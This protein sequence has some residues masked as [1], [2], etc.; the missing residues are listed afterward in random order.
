[1]NIMMYVMSSEYKNM[2]IYM[3]MNLSC[4]IMCQMFCDRMKT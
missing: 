1:M 2:K 3:P 4:E